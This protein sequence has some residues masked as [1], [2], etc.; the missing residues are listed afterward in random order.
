MKAV[1]LLAGKP[2]EEDLEYR[3]TGNDPG[4]IA[5]SM[6]VP[7]FYTEADTARLNVA[8]EIPTGSIHF[9]KVKGKSHAE[10]NIVGIAYLP[11]GSAAARFSDTVKLDFASQKELHAFRAQPLHYEKE[12]FAAPGSYTLKVAFSS[13][14]GGFGKLQVADRHPALRWQ[15]VHAQRPGAQQGSASHVRARLGA[16]Y[17]TLGRPYA[18]GV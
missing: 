16:G 6:Q 18:P 17:R 4:N 15:T 11:D 2:V 10:L 5:A 8:M 3:L 1:D 13:A 12:F 9:E 14:G 7:F